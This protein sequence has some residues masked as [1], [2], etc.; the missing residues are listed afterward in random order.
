MEHARLGLV[1]VY[2]VAVQHTRVCQLDIHELISSS[3]LHGSTRFFV[4]QVEL[5]VAVL[6]VVV[7]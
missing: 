2:V 1:G 3:Y 6:M 7:L 5:F 4:F